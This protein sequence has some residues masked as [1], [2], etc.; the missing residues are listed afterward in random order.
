MHDQ[1]S[2]MSIYSEFERLVK[3]IIPENE[4][5]TLSQ[6]PGE[7]PREKVTRDELNYM[8]A[9][10]ALARSATSFKSD[11]GELFRQWAKSAIRRAAKKIERNRRLVLLH[12]ATI[13]N[14]FTQQNLPNFLIVLFEEDR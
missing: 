12:I 10:I 9:Y 4:I 8:L 13:N 7:N 6:A 2:T 11:E 3:K 1:D 5:Y 14:D